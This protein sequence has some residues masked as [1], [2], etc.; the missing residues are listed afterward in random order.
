LFPLHRDG[1][2]GFRLTADTEAERVARGGSWILTAGS[3]RAADRSR[4]NPGNRNNYLGLRLVVYNSPEN[5]TTTKE[6]A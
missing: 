1:N 3:A 4:R 2:L 5:T 6:M